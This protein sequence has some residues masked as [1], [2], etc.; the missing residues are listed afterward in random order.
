VK[1]DLDKA[2]QNEKLLKKQIEGLQTELDNVKK[3]EKDSQ[4]HKA[5][6]TL[7]KQQL[8]TRIA[9]LETTVQSSNSEL[10]K[11]YEL[12]ENKKAEYEILAKEVQ[13]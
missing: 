3:A 13:I 9:Q 4:D 1:Q 8:E 7:E 6:G 5:R 10:L 2:P 12:V 11:M